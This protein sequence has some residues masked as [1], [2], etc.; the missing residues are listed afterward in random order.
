MIHQRY[1]IGGNDWYVAEYDPNDRLF[2]G[3]AVLNN[4]FQNAE[5]GYTSLDELANINVWGIEVDR[6]IHWKPRRFVEIGDI[7]RM[8]RNR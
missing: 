2:F 5:W 4:D 8:Y 1:F 6:D 7:P 3:Y